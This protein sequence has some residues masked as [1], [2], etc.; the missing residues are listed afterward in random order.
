VKVKELIEKLQS[1]T[2]EQKQYEVTTQAG[3]CCIDTVEI[4]DNEITID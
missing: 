2:D 3:C 1:L 4:L